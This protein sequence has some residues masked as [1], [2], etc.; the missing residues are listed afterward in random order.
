M[1]SETSHFPEQDD[2]S[3]SSSHKVTSISNSEKPEN[4]NY[5]FEIHAEQ[6]TASVEPQLE[7]WKLIL[8]TIALCS[9]IFC[10]SL[11]SRERCGY[12]YLTK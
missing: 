5:T 6:D 4:L 8:V 10:V 11:V 3:K 7:L 9:S 2:S 1:G 12:R